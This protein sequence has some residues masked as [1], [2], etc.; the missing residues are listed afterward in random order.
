MF[1]KLVLVTYPFDHSR[2]IYSPSNFSFIKKQKIIKFVS[3]T[4]IT[5]KRRTNLEHL[6]LIRPWGPQSQLPVGPMFT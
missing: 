5:F 4:T 6:E 2:R 3:I 1:Y